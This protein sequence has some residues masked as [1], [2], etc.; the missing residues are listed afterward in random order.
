MATAGS[1][2]IKTGFQIDTASYNRVE[3]HI[4]KISKSTT[5]ISDGFKKMGSV[6]KGLGA[7]VTAAFSIKAITAFTN[8]CK[9]LYEVQM[10]AE[11]KLETVVRQR[12]GLRNQE[13]QQIKDFASAIQG[14]GVVGDEVQLMGAAQLATFLSQKEALTTL[15]PALA[16]LLVAQKGLNGTATD[17]YNIG[18]ML[19]KVMQGQTAA[20]RRIGITFTEAEEKVL[21]YGT[22]LERASMLAKI[23]TNNVGEMNKAMAQTPL[24]RQ[25]QLKNTIG[26]IKEKFGQAAVNIGTLFLPVLQ[27]VA[28]WLDLVASAAIKVSTAIA[29]VFGGSEL[30]QSATPLSSISSDTES[31]VA[32]L[33][34]LGGAYEEAGKAASKASR[35]VLSFD[36]VIQ[37][38]K[39][40]DSGASG[41]SGSGSGASAGISSMSSALESEEV[42]G[43]IDSIAEKIRKTIDEIKNYL[44]ANV[45][46]PNLDFNTDL[47]KLDFINIIDN[48]RQ[49]AVD[50]GIFFLN[51]GFKFWND[52]D[53]V[54]IIE[55]VMILL[56]R[57]SET[58]QQ[59]VDAI[60]PAL[61][62]FYEV[63]IAPIVEWVGVKLK[64]ALDFLGVQI[65][66]VG[67]WFVLN[68]EN[69]DKF[70]QTLGE[71]VNIIWGFIEPIA[72]TAWEVFKT[73]IGLIVDG[74]LNLATWLMENHKL[75]LLIV[76]SI[77]EIWVIVQIPTIIAGIVSAVTSV[78]AVIKGAI[79]VVTTIFGIIAANPLMLIPLAIAAIVTAIIYLWNTN[80]DFRNFIIGVWENIK[81][82]F[83]AVW[84]SIKSAVS[85]GME[86][87]KGLV[88]FLVGGFKDGFEGSL[89]FI[90]SLIDTWVEHIKNVISSVKQIFG[91]LIDFVVGVFTGDWEKAFGG[92]K[93]IVLGVFKAIGSAVLVPFKQIAK[94]WNAIVGKIGT[95]TI[96][97]WVPGIGGNSFN[98][99]TITLPQLAHG[100]VVTGRTWAEIG[101]QGPEVVM[102]LRN[103]SFT[104]A[105]AADLVKA[106]AKYSP[107]P[108]SNAVNISIY[109][110]KVIG[111]DWSQIAKEVKKALEK[112]SIRVGGVSYAY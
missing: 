72:D 94:V 85:A 14:L 101:E 24:G 69:I 31:A 73:T 32:G 10:T 37:I 112:E 3:S 46:M 35:G 108:S 6:A 18:N 15:M 90:G 84:D 53:A 82:V 33:E 57:V 92:L 17:A 1:I 5:S 80:E 106:Q 26:D 83:I 2:S 36:N 63:G 95:L 87:L 62:T 12:M 66:K 56:Y 16:N 58:L 43:Q 22:E 4:K 55:N 20:L 11:T 78:I 13:I 44:S 111:N 103:N 64:D 93:D 52:I 99:P 19:G 48:L 81:A 59:A 100:G 71:I 30:K 109:A 51:I 102:P 86:V 41:G 110:D 88:D 68:K 74:L 105:F 75:I 29:R 34:D 98:L 7:A 67:T 104:E 89:G 42:D 23:I 61:T 8:E 107:T 79:G 9:K 21:Q 54:G 97:E 70:A 60:T 65:S 25:Q 49:I 40:S 50:A 77:A 47:I 45:E 38:N 27:K 76:A 96:P 39:G 28:V 91:G